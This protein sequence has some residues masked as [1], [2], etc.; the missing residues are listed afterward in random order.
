MKNQLFI[1]LAFPAILSCHH[2]FAQVSLPTA[3]KWQITGISASFGGHTDYFESMT[4]SDMKGR[5]A[6]P[7]MVD[8]DLEGYTGTFYQ[9]QGSPRLHVN[10]SFAP[11]GTQGSPFQSGIEYRL[12]LM[13]AWG[14]EALI[15]YSKEEDVS[16]G[17]TLNSSIM[18][19][20]VENEVALQTAVLFKKSY[21][22]QIQGY[23]GL[24]GSVSSTF[25]DRMLLIFSQHYTYEDPENVPFEEQDPGY[26]TLTYRAKHGMYFRG[27]IPVG[28]SVNF[29]D[30]GAFFTEGR[31]GAGF[32]QLTGGSSYL[33]KKSVSF[34]AG[35]KFFPGKLDETLDLF[36]SLVGNR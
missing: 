6:D 33:I 23:V 31:I 7:A 16:P 1:L 13:T 17:K 21:G 35:I 19:C 26:E 12:G 28:L 27:Y 14:K 30:V 5:A 2:L 32:H 24:G 29:Y 3:K 4:L 10:L 22:K 25:H 15:S 9:E 18:Y 36:A 8:L 34:N 20:D 11:G